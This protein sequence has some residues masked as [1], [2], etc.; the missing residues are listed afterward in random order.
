MQNRTNEQ[1]LVAVPSSYATAALLMLY[2]RNMNIPVMTIG[3][4]TGTDPILS[5]ESLT[6]YVQEGKVRFFLVPSYLENPES[7]SLLIAPGNNDQ[8]YKWVIDHG[9]KVEKE[10]WNTGLVTFPIPDPMSLY[11]VKG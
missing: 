10:L 3:G 6:R 1:F 7:K 5:V 8:I 9:R 11:D 4:F 2:D